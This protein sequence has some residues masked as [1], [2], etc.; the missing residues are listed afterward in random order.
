[1]DFLTP[2]GSFFYF[3]GNCRKTICVVNNETEMAMTGIL[4]KRMILLIFQ[5]HMKANSKKL[6]LT[7]MK[8]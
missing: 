6:I 5:T 3:L 8:T 7:Q 4:V 2:N 1:M